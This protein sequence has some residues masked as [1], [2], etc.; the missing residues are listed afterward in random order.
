M[1]T[2]SKILTQ[3]T[4]HVDNLGDINNHILQ[5][6]T[7]IAKSGPQ[8]K[9]SDLLGYTSNIHGKLIESR[10]SIVN[11]IELAEQGMSDVRI[12]ESIFKR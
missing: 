9:V 4:A 6:W 1:M 3:L 2:K 10:H 7:A 12:T 8:E 5:L 11:L